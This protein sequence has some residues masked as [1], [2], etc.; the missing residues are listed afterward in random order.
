MLDL[1]WLFHENLDFESKKYKLLAYVQRTETAFDSKKLYP[2]LNDVKLQKEN[3]RQIKNSK[4]SLSKA[5][6][7]TLSSI[8]V[9]NMTLDYQSGLTQRSEMDYLDEILRFSI[10]R[11][12][13]LYSIGNERRLELQNE[14][15]FFSIG[16]EPIYKREGYVFIRN[17]NQNKTNI[18]SFGINLI[19]VQDQLVQVKFS[20]ITSE[21]L[22]I[23]NTYDKMKYNLVK[24]DWQMPNPPVYVIETKVELPVYETCL[25][26][27][28]YTLTERIKKGD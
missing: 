26:L 2:F 11:L 7:K 10:P 1:N 5:M 19:E 20:Y 13:R 21:D 23:L 28:K 16:I 22:T 12:D 3:L 14:L 27:I 25:P 4:S 9:L 17:K 18:F 6:P 15:D 8:D 24:N